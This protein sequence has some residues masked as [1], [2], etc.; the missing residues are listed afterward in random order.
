[1]FIGNVVCPHIFSPY[2]DDHN[3]NDSVKLLCVFLPIA[4]SIKLKNEKD[5]KHFYLFAF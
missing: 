2:N 5:G 3:N 4:C 1:M